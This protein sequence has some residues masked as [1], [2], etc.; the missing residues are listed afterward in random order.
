MDL[1]NRLLILLFP[2]AY[3]KFRAVCGWLQEILSG[4][5]W[6]WMVSGGFGWFWVVSDGFEWFAVL[7]VIVLF[8]FLPFLKKLL[9]KVADVNSK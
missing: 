1:N 4:F 7:V 2:N 9:F 6:F 8:T 5:G 3:V